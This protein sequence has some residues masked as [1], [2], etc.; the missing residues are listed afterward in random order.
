MIE[1]GGLPA[2]YLF[3]IARLGY[4]GY[5]FI[6]GAIRSTS[7]DTVLEGR[8]MAAQWCSDSPDLRGPPWWPVATRVY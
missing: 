7:Y 8:D 5:M 4:G 1:K 2:V 3:C 6:V